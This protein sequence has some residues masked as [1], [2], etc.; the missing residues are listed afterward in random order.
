[1]AQD[2]K[3]RPL[4]SSDETPKKS[5]D[6]KVG[7]TITDELVIALCGPLGSPINSVSKELQEL[8][9]NSYGYDVVSIKLS[10][11]IITTGK[12]NIS[13]LSSFERIEKLINEGNKLRNSNE[14]IL[15]DL[16]IAQVA[17]ERKLRQ[18]KTSTKQVKPHRICHIINSIK[19]LHELERLRSIYRDLIFVVGVTSSVANRI[20]NLRAKFKN[21]IQVTK[22]IDRDSGEELENGQMVSDIFSESDFFINI[23]SDT[24]T[25]VS[26]KAKRFIDLI[27]RTKLLTPSPSETTM[28]NAASASA[29]SACLSRQVGAAILSKDNELISVGWND[30]PKYKGGL[31]I[32]T[33]TANDKRCFNWKDSECHNDYQKD[34]FTHHMI[35]ELIENKVLSSANKDQAF[36]VLRKSRRL[37]GLIEFSRSIHAEMTAIL[38]A[39]ATYEGGLQGSKLFCTTYP[40]HSC[41]RHIIAAGI[42]EVHYIEPY[43]K[44]LAIRLHSDAITENKNEPSKVKLIPYEGVAPSRYMEFFKVPINSRKING[45]YRTIDNKAAK[46]MHNQT[47]EAIP[48]LEGIVVSKLKEQG[49]LKDD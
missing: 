33:K 42:E 32:S 5:L 14:S 10:D 31:Y 7:G 43:K 23:G 44:S 3:Q 46:A 39:G 28:Y 38:N 34:E 21:D 22:L 15:A 18:E 40:C 13:N 26:E 24:S 25:E 30:V 8:L 45:K 47:L 35:N 6:E 49:L 36:T 2:S 11:I 9:E 41:A 12:I 48:T 19:N 29:N 16:A 20:E 37:K 4:I 27:L 17:K 1:M